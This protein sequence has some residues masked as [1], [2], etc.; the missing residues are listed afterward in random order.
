M[1][2][3]CRP[4]VCRLPPVIIYLSSILHSHSSEQGYQ[5]AFLTLT[6]DS[7]CHFTRVYVLQ[8]IFSVCPMVRRRPILRT[9]DY[10]FKRSIWNVSPL[11]VLDS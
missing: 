10:C 2:G 8:T 7:L 9:P 1:T 4:P 11:M 5:D 3:R 6:F